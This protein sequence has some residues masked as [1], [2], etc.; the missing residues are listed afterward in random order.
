MNYKVCT[1]CNISKPLSD[2]YKDGDRKASC[3]KEC[4]KKNIRA[5]YKEKVDKVN[6]YKSERGC[7]KCGET[8]HWM[9]DFHH[10]NPEEKEFAISDAI[11]RKFENILPEMEKCDILCANC[12]RDWHYRSENEQLDYNAWLGEMA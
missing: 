9:L 2:Y 10:A 4:H 12:H 7:R 11:R 8:R 6:A 5:T 3:C 1:Q